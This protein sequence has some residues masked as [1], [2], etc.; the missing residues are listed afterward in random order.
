L[1][2]VGTRSITATDTNTSSITGAQTGIEVD[3][4]GAASLAVSGFTS[5]TTAGV[6]HSVNV[7]AKDA[8]ANTA[9]GYAGTVH[10]TSSDGQA[11]L[12]S[13]STLT[14]GT[15]SFNATLK[16]VGTRSI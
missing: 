8:Y 9:T 16:T 2:T 3:P 5:P 15:G 10:F 12:P 7:T 4:A 13:D 6:Q 1:K 11:A 14:N